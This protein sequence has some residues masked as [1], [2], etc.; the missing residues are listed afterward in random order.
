MYAINCM[1]F[2]LDIVI[3]SNLIFCDIF[4][5]KHF[6]YLR[7]LI[8]DNVNHSQVINIKWLLAKMLHF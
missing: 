6:Q 2:I 5:I 4:F 1:I 7:W 3:I 8:T